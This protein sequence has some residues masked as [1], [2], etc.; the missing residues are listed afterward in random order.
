MYHYF[1]HFSTI[2]D[3]YS[4]DG[5]EALRSPSWKH[6]QIPLPC[7]REPS[8]HHSLAKEW[9]RIQRRAP[10]WRHQGERLIF[11]FVGDIPTKLNFSKSHNKYQHR[12]MLTHY[13][14]VFIATTST[15]EP[16]HGECGSLRPWELQLCGGEQIWVHCSHLPLGRVG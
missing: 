8:S 4:K 15:L 6:C 2:L 13:H 11:W 10:D 5:E 1:L 14:F 3:S 12:L 9:Q 7:H 16:G